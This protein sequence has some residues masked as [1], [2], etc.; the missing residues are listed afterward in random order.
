M[1]N[2]SLYEPFC[3]S[4]SGGGF[5]GLEAGGRKKGNCQFC[6]IHPARG[7]TTLTPTLSRARERE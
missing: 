4:E 7:W 5:G 3:I 1:Q 6:P 2:G